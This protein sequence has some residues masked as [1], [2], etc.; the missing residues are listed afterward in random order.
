MQVQKIILIFM[1]IDKLKDKIKIKVIIHIHK[2][3]CI[4]QVN[5]N[6]GPIVILI[7]LIHL[8]ITQ[9]LIW[10]ELVLSYKKKNL[11][12]NMTSSFTIQN[13]IFK[14]STK[15]LC[16]IIDIYFKIFD[17]FKLKTNNFVKKIIYHY[18]KNI[19]IIIILTLL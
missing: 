1:E 2:Y 6:L 4:K 5:N 8:L 13:L 19:N 7:I 17:I 12:N 16:D 11:I 14:K 9:I 15:M 3:Q 18:I 10:E